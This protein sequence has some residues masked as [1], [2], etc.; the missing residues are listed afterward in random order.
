VLGDIPYRGGD[1][2]AALEDYNAALIHDPES[3]RLHAR[4]AELQA[5]VELQGDF[6]QSPGA[7]FTV[8]FEGPADETLALQVLEILD[9]AY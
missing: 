4:V 8:L 1:M 9:A 6:F 2:T 5:E 3:E 7:H